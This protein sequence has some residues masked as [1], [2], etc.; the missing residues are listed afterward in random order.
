MK[1]IPVVFLA[2]VLALSIMIPA[3]AQSANAD[4][5][6]YV[7]GV[8]RWN[9]PVTLTAYIPYDPATVPDPTSGWFYEWIRDIMNVDLQ[10]EG[11][12]ASSLGDRHS[13]M[14]ASG[15]L[16][17]VLLRW[18]VGGVADTTIYGDQ[19]G[20]LVP[21]NAYLTKDIMPNMCAILEEF[22]G[23]IR[24]IG[25]PSGNLY[26]AP[27]IQEHRE[28][29][30]IAWHDDA[31]YNVNDM[32]AAGY[33]TFPK[34]TDELLDYARKLKEIDP[35]GLGDKYYPLGGGFDVNSMDRYLAHAFGLA[36]QRLDLLCTVYNGTLE[37]GGEFVFV[38]TSDAYYEY[39]KYMNTLYNEGLIEKDYFTIDGATI[40]AR[41]A[42]GHYSVV[43][44]YKNMAGAITD[45]TLTW[46]NWEIMDPLTSPIN[47]VPF[48]VGGYQYNSNAYVLVS[49]NTTDLQR[50]AAF[51]LLDYGY[52]NED[53]F[54]WRYC[55]GP[56]AG[57]DKL[58]GFD[59]IGWSYGKHNYDIIL[60][61][62]STYNP[63][64]KFAMTQEYTAGQVGIFGA[65]GGLFDRRTDGSLQKFNTTDNMGGYISDQRWKHYSPYYREGFNSVSLP[66]AQVNRSVDL[67]TVL[68][69]HYKSER[70]KFITG[71][72]A[73][74][75]DEWAVYCGEMEAMDA[76]EYFQIQSDAFHA[77]Y[78]P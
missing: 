72:R 34:T 69:D 45:E 76:D 62:V 67:E 4:K 17:N 24:D 25:T 77:F 44:G 28:Y 70:A 16:P 59:I 48:V 27:E 11:I 43:S 41:I 6:A 49:S 1:R 8:W 65:G 63:E 32:K 2:M 30:T 13:L 58:Y 56:Q 7:N 37:E 60:N 18:N 22:P 12:I 55:N 9:E 19:E 75:E 68:L 31:W 20:L 53:G 54:A 23:I 38:P 57:V 21:M 10:I 29:M 33:E 36:Q 74:T 40:K 35:R 26:L 61:D 73:L 78:R 42:E 5:G 46:P 3:S 51:R 14:M 71:V 64:G 66:D 15:E 39:L 50:E 47:D 52:N